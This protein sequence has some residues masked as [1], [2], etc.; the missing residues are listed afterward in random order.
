MPDIRTFVG[1]LAVG[2]GCATS[3]AAETALVAT[4]SNFADTASR[5]VEQFEA[6]PAHT[7]KSIKISLGATGKLYAQIRAGAPFHVLLSADQTR[8]KRLEVEGLAVRGSSFTYAVGQLTLWSA[9][10]ARVRGDPHAVL[11]SASLRTIAIANPA[12]A[13]YGL[14]AEQTL[15]NLGL[16]RQLRS[17]F[18]VGENI[19]QA[20]ALAATGNATVGFVARPLLE[21][22]RGKALKGSRWDVPA[23]MHDPIRQDA[24]LLARG[25]Q[26]GAAKAFLKYLQSEP[27]RAVINAHGYRLYLE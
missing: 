17:R 7:G 27:A 4:A 14:A 18:V 16:L 13:P 12:L 26:N 23:S 24:V 25:A 3:A 15:S 20:F 9:D 6:N 8:P 11:T 19:G 2:I 10:P 1:A 5:L 22:A 21:S